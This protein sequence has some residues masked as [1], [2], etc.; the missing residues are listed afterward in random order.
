MRETF[1]HKQPGD[2]LEAAHVNQ[3][4]A[5]AR[6]FAT[7]KCGS[8]LRSRHGDSFTSIAS[9]PPFMQGRF[10]VVNDDDAADGLYGIQPRYY[11]RTDEEWITDSDDTIRDLDCSAFSAL[12]RLLVNEEVTAYWDEQRGMYLPISVPLVRKATALEIINP[13]SSGLARVLNAGAA[14]Q[15]TPRAWLN[16]M[17]NDTPILS[18]L[19]ILIQFFVDEIDTATPA[20]RGKWIVTNAECG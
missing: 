6:R 2:S 8:Y 16:H 11:S 9:P 17:H 13:E 4:S 14:T 1:P 15:W 18:G 3:L 10:V 5:V 19:D 20:P 7:L 12:A